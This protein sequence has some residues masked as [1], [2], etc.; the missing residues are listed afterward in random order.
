MKKLLSLL[1]CLIGFQANA[2]TDRHTVTVT[3]LDGV[4][5]RLILEAKGPSRFDPSREAYHLVADTTITGGRSAT[6]PIEP[7]EELKNYR[8]RWNSTEED[9][10]RKQI[11]Y[12]LGSS[13]NSTGKADHD[14]HFNRGDLFVIE[15]LR[16]LP[17]TPEQEAE[18]LTQ[19]RAATKIQ[20]VARGHMVR[21]AARKMRGAHAAEAHHADAR[22]A[23]EA[24][25]HSA[26]TKIQALYKGNKAR[27][28][29][30]IM[31][32]AAE[33]IRHFAKKIQHKKDQERLH[34]AA[35]DIQRVVRGHM[36]RI[37]VKVKVD[38]TYGGSTISNQNYQTHYIDMN[39]KARIST[40]SGN[41]E[42]EIA[43]KPRSEIR[44]LLPREEG[45]SYERTFQVGSGPSDQINIQLKGTPKGKYAPKEED[46][47][48]VVCSEGAQNH[49]AIRIQAAERGRTARKAV[50]ELKA[51]KAATKLQAA[52]RGMKD[53]RKVHDMKT[54]ASAHGVTVHFDPKSAIPDA[55]EEI[56]VTVGDDTK[57]WEEIF[58]YASG[59]GDFI[60]PAHALHPGTTVSFQ[61]HNS[62]PS[63]VGSPIQRVT[64]TGEQHDLTILVSHDLHHGVQVESAHWGMPEAEHKSEA[65]APETVPDSFELR[66]IHEDAGKVDSNVDYFLAYTDKDGPYK[67]IESTKHHIAHPQPGTYV[68][69][70]LPNIH[71]AFVY[72]KVFHY[73]GGVVTEEV[74]LA[75][76]TAGIIPVGAGW[77]TI[78]KTSSPRATTAAATAPETVHVTFDVKG[79]VEVFKRKIYIWDYDSKHD[80]L[81]KHR[82]PRSGHTYNIRPYSKDR[83]VRVQA[84]E[85][86][87]LTSEAVPAGKSNLRVEIDADDNVSFHWS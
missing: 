71:A 44:V 57:A 81:L 38:F 51:H 42:S 43:A 52:A 83:K 46:Q 32:S 55:V 5:G 37:P 13:F 74:K 66:F 2:A 23:E 79:S 75:V 49:A 82:L 33:T 17:L 10:R 1:M 31:H 11:M 36:T 45:G 69:V 3:G 80:L 70:Q 35:T 64:Y 25:H 65:A 26:A 53:R 28:H 41:F 12:Q 56:V 86:G 6:L 54:T 24:R 72:E 85:A 48:S 62:I 9:A 15:S 50:G 7:S 77:E 73:P 22:A 14:I 34:K 19:A 18:R 60:I 27:E 16:M 67:R 59:L 40:K 68:I 84:G 58:E 4:N 20:S 87:I 63:A 8:V 30:G 76:G 78:P 39:G 47:W 21:E 29:L 61:H